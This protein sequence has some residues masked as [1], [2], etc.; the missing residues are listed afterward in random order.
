MATPTRRSFT[1]EGADGLPLRGDVYTAGAGAGRPAAVICHGFKGFK[2]WGF[3]PPLAERLARAGM[4]AVSFNFS[5]SGVGEARDRF[6]EP[7]RFAH[8]TYSND[9]RDLDVVLTALTA[10]ALL[11]EQNTPTAVGLVGHSRGGG[12]AILQTANDVRVR[13]LVTWAAIGSTLRWG[14][15]T[16]TEWR[17]TGYL[18]VTNSRTGEVL[19]LST[20]VLDDLERHR[21]RLDIGRAAEAVRVPWLIVHGE[22]DETVSIGDARTLHAR[23]AG[24][25]ELLTIPHGSHTLG[26]KHPWAGATPA[27]ERGFDATVEWLSRYLF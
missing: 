1:L 10:G 16:I 15:H 13:A 18:N 7:E 19:P 27:V 21:E 26:A 2:D 8:W 4:T 12:V 3:F 11:P 9:L 5:G 25:A 6:D 23:N 24:R 14:P 17:R 20:D 22:S